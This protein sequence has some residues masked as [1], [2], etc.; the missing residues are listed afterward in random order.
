MIHAVFP[1]VFDLGLEDG[2]VPGNFEL[3][4]GGLDNPVVTIRAHQG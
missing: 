2:Q 4:Q 3:G 1:S